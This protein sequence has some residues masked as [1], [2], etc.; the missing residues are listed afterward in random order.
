M[1]SMRK[2]GRPAKKNSKADYK[3]LN[4]WIGERLH[5]EA[6]S[7]VK[8]DANQLLNGPVAPWAAIIPLSTW[9]NPNSLTTKTIQRHWDQLYGLRAPNLIE[10]LREPAASTDKPLME[11]LGRSRHCPPEL[12]SHLCRDDS[13]DVRKALA[14]NPNISGELLVRL[15]TD[16]SSAVR[17][18]VAAHRNCPDSILESFLSS[19]DWELR[20]KVAGN[21]SCPPQLFERLAADEDSS[22]RSTLLS[23]QK[24][25]AA[26]WEENGIR[27]RFGNTRGDCRIQRMP[28]SHPAKFVRR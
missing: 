12:L 19:R 13:S 25:P 23:S 17:R 18:A 2:F 10:L 27:Q 28:A 14:K 4:Q 11:K 7:T 26:L 1:L 20:A 3:T 24:L 22:V 6:G 9:W 5:Q 8:A 15:S 21:R 16:R